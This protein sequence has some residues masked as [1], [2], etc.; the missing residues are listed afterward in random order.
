MANWIVAESLERLRAQLNA[1]APNRSKAGDGGIGDD[2]HANRSSDHN[3][4]YGPG[5]VTARD[6]THDPA[7]GLSCATLAET[8]RQA[9]DSRI[10]YVIWNR[11]T[12][13]R[14][15]RGSEHQR[16]R[17]LHPPPAQEDREGPHP[18]RHG[19]RLGV[20]SREDSLLSRM[21]AR[22]APAPA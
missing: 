2:D 9:K 21:S 8:L 7:G 1:L 3:P 17:G 13:V 10:K 22:A 11:R 12:P 6:F 18:H 19:A 5:I 20:L 14:V 15:G 16:H 4:W